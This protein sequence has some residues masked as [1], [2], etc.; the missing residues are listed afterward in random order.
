[1]NTNNNKC[2]LALEILK[3]FRRIINFI[4]NSNSS[5]SNSNSNSSNN[6]NNNSGCNNKTRINNKI[7][8]N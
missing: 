4:N 1:M 3:I 6:N 2:I 7:I 5:N 8:V